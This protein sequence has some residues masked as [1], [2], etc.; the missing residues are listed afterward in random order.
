MKSSSDRRLTILG[1]EITNDCNLHCPHCYNPLVKN[2]HTE[3]TLDQCI[4]IIDSAANLG[5]TMIGWTGGEP[6]LRLDLEELIS[7]ALKNHQIKSSI[8]SNGVLL[9]RHRGQ[10]LKNAGLD[11]IQISLDG[12]TAERSRLIRR[13][14]DDE[15]KNIIEAIDVCTD[16]DIAVYLA[17]LLGAEN[18]DDGYEMLTIAR[19]KNVVGIR[20]CGFT[21]EG[22]ARNS[23]IQQR[24]Q[25]GDRLPELHDFIMKA[26]QDDTIQAIFDP[27]F[28][29]VP[30]DY[31]FHECIAGLE[32]CY[33]KANGDVYPCTAMLYDQFIVGNVKEHSLEQLWYDPSMTAMSS[34][35]TDE[36]E[37]ICGNC[38]NSDSC[39]GA[40]RCL[41]YAHTGSFDES[42]PVCL[43]QVGQKLQH[44]T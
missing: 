19:D 34:Y 27:G 36:I 42:F 29:P 14:T 9:D 30:P 15:F 13:T 8:T 11:N 18:L 37:G 22:R 2:T 4:K 6:L 28:G 26:S 44:R 43:Y 7:Y 16:L 32:T 24:F 3:L 35:P 5:T 41:T 20:F 38:D 12:T 10:S 39:S 21:P 25:F 33:I 31:W 23:K 40:C 17:M 1:W